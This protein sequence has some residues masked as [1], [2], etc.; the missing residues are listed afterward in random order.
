[1]IFRQKKEKHTSKKSRKSEES[2]ATTRP[3]IYRMFSMQ[4]DDIGEVSNSLQE[5]LVPQPLA[6]SVKKI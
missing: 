2:N 3:G 6:Q 5:N 1:M 4:E